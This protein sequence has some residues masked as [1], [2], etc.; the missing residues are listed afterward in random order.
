MAKKEEFNIAHLFFTGAVMF[1]GGAAVRAIFGMLKRD[2]EDEE[3]AE[4]EL[5]AML[6]MSEP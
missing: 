5:A 6:I 4:D 3:S 2:K 1:V